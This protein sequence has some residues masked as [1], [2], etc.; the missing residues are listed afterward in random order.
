[1]P[2]GNV[3]EFEAMTQLRRAMFRTLCL[4][5][6]GFLI[7]CNSFVE[8]GSTP[9][10]RDNRPDAPSGEMLLDVDF[11]DATVTPHPDKKLQHKVDVLGI[12]LPSGQPVNAAIFYEGGDPSGRFAKVIPDPTKSGNHV[13]HYWLKEAQV[14]SERK[15][16]YKG[17]IQMI[18]ADLQW[19]EAYQRYR[20][21]LHPDLKPYRSYPGESTWFT[22]NELWFGASWEGHPNP[23]RITLGIAK[24]KGVG[25]PLG[26]LAT[27]EIKEKGK[28]KPVWHS[29]NDKFEVPIGEWLDIEVGYKQGDKN[30]GRFYVAVKRTSDAVMTTIVD[31]HDWTYHPRAKKPVP[32]TQWNPLKLYTSS[33]IIDF[34]RN[35]GGA[36]Q[37][38]YD[39]L[40]IL[41]KW[42]N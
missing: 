33:S 19:T 39:D 40:T 34:I 37:I 12:K 29:F 26:F 11:E 16:R 30:T 21:Y 6:I 28:W 17:R 4:L 15:G 36:T 10:V 27:G 20:M 13:L 22:I 38:Y 24:E 9:A 8:A 1:M 41:K 7:S 42:P 31:V 2:K 3:M 25:K 5:V 23:F 14:S 18:L 35:H 32:M